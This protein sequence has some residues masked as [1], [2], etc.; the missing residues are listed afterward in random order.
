[1]GGISLYTWTRWFASLEETFAN[2]GVHAFSKGSL[3]ISLSFNGLNNF[4]KKS[5]MLGYP[6]KSFKD[7]CNSGGSTGIAVVGSSRYQRPEGWAY[8]ETPS[9]ILQSWNQVTKLLWKGKAAASW[10]TTVMRSFTVWE[11]I[12]KIIKYY[13]PFVQ[14]SN[15]DLE[16]RGIV[17]QSREGWIIHSCAGLF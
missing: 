8:V 13:Q 6:L 17:I 9:S 7:M 14:G 4:N 5:L 12:F 15:S 10:T 3:I 16:N 1:M 2:S 11:H